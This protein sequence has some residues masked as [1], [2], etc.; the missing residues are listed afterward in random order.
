IA[1]RNP[2]A[3]FRSLPVL[4]KRA[5]ISVFF[6]DTDGKNIFEEK[7]KI[8]LSDEYEI[9][10]REI[11]E[12]IIK[13]SNFENTRLAVPIEGI[14]RSIWIDKNRCIIDFRLAS[15]D[16]SAIIIPGSEDI[17][18]EAVTRSVKKNIPGIDEVLIMEN[19][20]FGRHL[21]EP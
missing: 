17:F 16:E 14:I 12:M 2:L 4:D 21:W 11:V 13:G 3:V 20:I 19:G 8:R 5:E 6:P 9:Q 1:G 7:R 18:K 15:L 10:I